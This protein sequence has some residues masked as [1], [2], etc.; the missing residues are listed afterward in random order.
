MCAA[1]E[2]LPV[3]SL[4]SLRS[5]KFNHNPAGFHNDALTIRK[6]HATPV[7][8]PEWRRGASVKHADSRAAYAIRET[9]G[10]T[11][12]IQASFTTPHPEDCTE[13]QIRAV[14]PLPGAS[15]PKWLFFLILL[16]LIVLRLPIPFNIIGR[17]RERPIT[18]KPDGTSDFE[19]F[20]LDN[21]LMWGIPFLGLKRGVVG[22]FDVTWRWQW[23]VGSSG[24][25]KD[26]ENSRHRIY[27]V[28]EGP[29]APWSQSSGSPTA[30]PWA[31]ALELAC[32]WAVGASTRTEAAT[33]ITQAVNGHPLQSY[34]PNTTFGFG[35]YLLTSYINAV[36]GSAPFILNCT[37]CADA[38]TTFSNLLG[39]DLCEGRFEN[40]VTH[41][42][43][44]LNGNPSDDADWVSW[45][46][47]YHEICF[48]NQMGE[49]ERI[50]DGCLQLDTDTDYTDTVHIPKLPAN[51]IFHE[52]RGLLVQSGPATLVPPG[53]HRAII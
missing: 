50:F 27:V 47:N 34:T 25:W 33:A 49:N 16:I 42:F 24:S 3:L 51:M 4:V 39:C 52:Y 32:G 17:V 8:I 9:K 53:K 43:L 19:T 40:M 5:I 31:D 18:F 13:V 48:V 45:G 44:K 12:T 37:D 23:R 35:T 38:V 36:N 26:F 28:L 6:N 46:W 7:S 20:E 14:D 11:L 1:R 15:L 29:K 21:V 2:G 22:K 41:R 30:W 10:K